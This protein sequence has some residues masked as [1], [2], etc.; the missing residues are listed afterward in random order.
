MKK[1]L[2]AATLIA[3]LMGSA[4]ANTDYI[5]S[6]DDIQPAAPWA[7]YGIHTQGDASGGSVVVFESS[8][9]SYEKIE[10]VAG[11]MSEEGTATGNTV[12]MTGGTVGD[13]FGGSALDMVSNNAVTMSGGAV[14]NLLGGVSSFREASNNLVVYTG[15]ASCEEAIKGGHSSQ[16]ASDNNAVILSG[17]NK[18]GYVYGGYGRNSVSNNRVHLVGEGFQ[19]IVENVEVNGS[20]IAVDHVIAGYC[21][22]KGT[23]ADNAIHLYGTGIEVGSWER[24]QSLNFHLGNSLLTSTSPMVALVEN[25]T[26]A[27]TGDFEFSFDAVESMNWKP[28][29]SVTLVSAQFIF[30]LHPE[31]LDKEYNIYQYGDPEKINAIATGRLEL[32]QDKTLLK[33]VVTSTIPE[34]ATG[35]LSLLALAALAA[36]RRKK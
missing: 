20:A 29:D 12:T 10:S 14:T 1:T 31:E 7:V 17:G 9:S 28:G 33:L 6:P 25:S 23:V 13:L 24:F 18:C 22:K 16:N 3:T 34:P 2:F 19:G 26:F 32:N 21:E 5:A 36:R 35:T 27:L 15:S 30:A 4:H 8:E 11:G